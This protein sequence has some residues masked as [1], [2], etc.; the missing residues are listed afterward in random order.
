ML[1]TIKH[2]SDR[3]VPQQIMAVVPAEGQGSDDSPLAR[4]VEGKWRLEEEQQEESVGAGQGSFLA[5]FLHL[6]AAVDS[7]T[8]TGKPKTPGMTWLP[9]P[10]KE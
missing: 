6:L 1:A 2:V 5:R 10:P 4:L 9:K 7:E 8:Q 3:D